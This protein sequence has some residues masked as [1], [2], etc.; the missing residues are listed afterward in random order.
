MR[1][2]TK[3]YAIK[4]QE[5]PEIGGRENTKMKFSL[6]FCGIINVLTAIN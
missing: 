4:S 6:K 1:H 3:Y 2:T 5:I